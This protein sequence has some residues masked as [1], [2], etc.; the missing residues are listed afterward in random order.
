MPLKITL[1]IKYSLL[2]L[3]RLQ[4]EKQR[5]VSHNYRQYDIMNAIDPKTGQK[6]EIYFDV[7]VPLTWMAQ[8][9]KQ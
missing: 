3:F 2:S 6:Y 5:L 1:P 4:R 7:T 9:L 8:H